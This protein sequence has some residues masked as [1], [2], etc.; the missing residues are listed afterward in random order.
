MIGVL[1]IALGILG[2]GK[3]A[4]LVPTRRRN[5]PGRIGVVA[6]R[7]SAQCAVCHHPQKLLFRFVSRNATEWKGLQ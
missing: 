6:N 4:W 3:E 7:E 5:E 1:V 2:K